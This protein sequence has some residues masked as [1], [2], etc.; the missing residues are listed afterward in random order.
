MNPTRNKNHCVQAR[1]EGGFGMKNA[2][3]AFHSNILIFVLEIFALGWMMSGFST[4]VFSSSR[5]TAL[6]YFT[7]DSNILMGII[8]LITAISEWKVM[9]GKK[10]DISSGS[11]IL[12]L[13][14]TTGVTL[15]MLVTV[16]FLAPKMEDFFSLFYYSNL[17]LHLIN[18]V[19]SIL[20]FIC[21]ENT[22][23]ISF[24]H[25]FLGIIPMLIYAVYYI[26]E[27]L[28]H[29]RDGVI[30][31]GYDWYGFFYDGARSVIIVLPVLI[32]V[33][34]VISLVLWKGNKRD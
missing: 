23:K 11:Y 28:I 9:K 21:F 34:Y 4:G 24:R 1:R 25:T 14:G 31:K 10:E 20:T 16:F 29:S 26:E 13:V 7:V 3:K 17:F 12:K 30:L 8:A 6:R 2:G 18:P 22:E 19:L 33:T 5:W 27:S 32:L 15:T